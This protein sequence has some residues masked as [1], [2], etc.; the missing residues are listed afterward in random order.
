MDIWAFL[1]FGFLGGI[2]FLL[3]GGGFWGVGG[4]GPVDVFEKEVTS[5][6]S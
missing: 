5:Q 3:E 4:G 2:S 1:R 6:V